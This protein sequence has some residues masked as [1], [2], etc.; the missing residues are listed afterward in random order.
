MKKVTT[1]LF[2]SDISASPTANKSK[3][4]NCH[5]NSSR[6][7]NCNN[8]YRTDSNYYPNNGSPKGAAPSLSLS[9]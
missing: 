5:V 2:P 9:L 6:L 3:T 7:S 1:S 4:N 8:L